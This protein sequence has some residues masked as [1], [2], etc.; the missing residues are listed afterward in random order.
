MASISKR[1]RH[2]VEP[3]QDLALSNV[4]YFSHARWP[5]PPTPDEAAVACQT[6]GRDVPDFLDK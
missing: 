4:I 6:E 3:P 1:Q 2:G 5:P